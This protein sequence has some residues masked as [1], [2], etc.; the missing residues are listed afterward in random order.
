MIWYE[1][2]RENKRKIRLKLKLTSKN[3]PL[4]CFPTPSVILNKW[5]KTH[6]YLF[7][8]YCKTRT[9]LFTMNLNT[10][11]F[12]VI[13]IESYIMQICHRHISKKWIFVANAAISQ[14]FI[15][16]PATGLEYLYN[17]KRI[18]VSNVYFLQFRLIECSCAGFVTV[19]TKSVH[20]NTI[21]HETTTHNKIFTWPLFIVFAIKN[22]CYLRNSYFITHFELVRSLSLRG[23]SSRDWNVDM[24]TSFSLFGLT[25]SGLVSIVRWNVL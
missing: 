5:I 21:S 18:L 2:V 15:R 10:F 7:I 20:W 13:K 12:N 19:V 23:I 4:S 8:F 1:L 25:S 22:G 3:L 14:N 9:I 24:R 11:S 6:P 16:S 17:L